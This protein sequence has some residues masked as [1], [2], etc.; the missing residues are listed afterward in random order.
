MGREI[1]R[2]EAVVRQRLAQSLA[3]GRGLDGRVEREE[4]GAAE[5]ERVQP[6]RDVATR[7]GRVEE[8]GEGRGRGYVRRG[9]P[10]FVVQRAVAGQVDLGGGRKRVEQGGE[11]RERVAVVLGVEVRGG[12]AGC[13]G[14]GSGGVGG[15]VGWDD[16]GWEEGGC[17]ERQRGHCLSEGKGRGL[18]KRREVRGCLNKA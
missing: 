10:V 3:Q 6:V 15:H 2:D 7:E 11:M 5:G 8:G 13:G 4:G 14:E 16:G 9:Q 12:D 17:G 1:V 18:A